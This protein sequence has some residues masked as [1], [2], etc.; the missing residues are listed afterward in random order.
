MSILKVLEQNMSA[1][2]DA[3]SHLLNSKNDSV[4]RGSEFMLYALVNLYKDKELDEI[5][6]GIIDSAYRA[7]KNDCS[8]DA[9][10]ITASND[11]VES[12]DELDSCNDDTK[13]TIQL[14]QFKRGSGIDQGDLL[15]YQNGIKKAFIEGK[16]SKSKNEYFH[17]RFQ[18]LN[19]I[20]DEIYKKFS[21]DNIQIVCNIVFGGLKSNVTNDENLNYIPDQIRSALNQNGYPKAAVKIIDCQDLISAKSK[22]SDILEIVEYEKTFKY[23]TENS[24]SIE[25]NGY[26]SVIK[27]AAIAKLVKKHQSLIFE[28][29]IRDYFKRNDLNSKIIKTSSDADEAKLFWSY[30]NGLTVTCSKVE[31]MPN[32]KYKLHNLQIVNGCQ[33]SNAIYHAFKNKER[34]IELT[35]KGSELTSKE[36]EELLRINP[37]QLSDDVTLLVKIIE[38]KDDEFIHKITERTNSQ[39]PIK[40]YSLKA[41][42]DIQ[43]LIQNYLE[44][45]EINY[46]RRVNYLRNKGFKNIYS[47]QKVFQLYTSQILFKP[48]QIKAHPK[49]MFEQTYDVVFPSP[50]HINVDYSLYLIP[51][52]VDLAIEKKISQINKS[53]LFSNYTDYQKML[54]IYGKYHLGCF[55]LSSICKKNYNQKFIIENSVK[56]IHELDNRFDKHFKDALDNFEATMIKIAGDKLESIPTTIRKIELDNLTAKFL[57]TRKL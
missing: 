49:R 50:D 27:G 48:S 46:E 5:E 38:T 33:T 53:N 15:K 30:N 13:F 19:I 31:E 37:L 25:L 57:N 39:T 56:I 35:K 52:K 21:A 3:Y 9:Y 7:E 10:F 24:S 44:S 36:E 1:S 28:A 14:F 32:N 34:F 54:F 42:D 43:K 8:I 51:I 2:K 12:L 17:N 6:V 47:I 22:G 40:S 55:V 11:F 18:N 45:N 26:I 4:N 41:N 20:R 23:I 16:F 29:N